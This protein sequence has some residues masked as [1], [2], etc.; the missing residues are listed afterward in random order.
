MISKIFGIVSILSLIL[1]IFTGKTEQIG[2]SVAEGADSAVRLVI[3]LSGMMCLWSGIVRV[4]EY[5]GITEVLAKIISPF[6]KIMLP[7]A[8]NLKK[9]G[10]KDAVSA[11]QSVSANIS[12][13]ILGIGNAATPAPV[14]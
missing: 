13:N 6:L 3:S 14:K 5:I 12:A 2:L 10:D 4:M 1:A 9:L 8:Y 7:H 11:L